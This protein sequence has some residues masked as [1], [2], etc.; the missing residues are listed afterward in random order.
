M[1]II[2][3]EK[4]KRSLGSTHSVDIKTDYK[5][6]NKGTVVILSENDINNTNTLNKLRGYLIDVL[7]I[8]KKYKYTFNDTEYFDILKIQLSDKPTITY[9]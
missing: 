3:I 6:L 2:R 5:N 4:F 1:N 7:V 8:P 9:Y